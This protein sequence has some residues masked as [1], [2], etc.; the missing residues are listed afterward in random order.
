MNALPPPLYLLDSEGMSFGVMVMMRDV[1]EL[2][3]G[4]R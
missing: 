3:S 1:C 2:W 4:R